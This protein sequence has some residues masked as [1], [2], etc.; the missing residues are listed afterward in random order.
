MLAADAG[1]HE[2]IEKL[3]KHDASVNAQDSLGRTA[4]TRACN[5]GHEASQQSRHQQAVF[6]QH[7][8]CAMP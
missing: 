5:A 6:D 4:L 8:T 1:H 3:I 7:R 2:L